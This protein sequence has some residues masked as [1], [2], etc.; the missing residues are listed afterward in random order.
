MSEM[1]EAN[2]IIELIGILRQNNIPEE[3]YKNY[4]NRFLE[5]KA[6]RLYIPI[7]GSFELTPFCNLDCKM[8]YVHL[9]K[10]QFNRN[11]LLT[12][13][14]WKE[15]MGQAH[16]AGMLKATLTGGECL[17]YSGFD[18]LYLYL[19]DMGIRPAVLSNGVLIDDDRI[20]FFKKYPPKVIQIS[21]YGSSDEAYERVTGHRV[22]NTV[23]K[24]LIALKESGIRVRLSITPSTFM[25]TD[26]YELIKVAKDL[27]LPT[28]INSKLIAPRENTG[29]TLIELSI[30]DYIDIY[31]AYAEVYL[32]SELIPIDSKELPEAN[33]CGKERL[34]LLCGGGRSGFVIQS[35]GNMSPCPS[36]AFIK[37][38]PLEVG[39][40]KAWNELYAI[41]NKFPIPGECDG[42]AY[43][44]YC[45]SCPAIHYN[46]HNVGHCN[47]LVCERTKRFVQEG[48]IKMPSEQR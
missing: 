29:R 14:E 39:F 30:D 13:Q 16:K 21:L 45:L 31:R 47:P 42:C 40:T 46:E 7:Q 8:C 43:Q 27:K 23:Y 4:Y 15:L 2:S 10:S 38:Q 22:F 48:I 20:Q 25:K 34:G 24:N 33:T 3:E 6:R 41:V 12:V 18:E 9:T 26:F 35:D 17:T 19:Y 1:K 32:E 44:A 11:L 28:Y 37:T 5:N 36:L